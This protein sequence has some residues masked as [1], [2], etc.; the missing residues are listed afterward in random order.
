MQ[1]AFLHGLVDLR[2]QRAVL[3]ADRLGVATVD[4]ALEATEMR[5]HGAGQQPILGA[6]AL[7]ALRGHEAELS[8][9]T[10]T[11]VAE[12]QTRGEGLALTVTE[13]LSGV[14]YNG[15]GRYDEALAEWDLQQNPDR[16]PA[17]ST[18]AGRQQAMSVVHTVATSP[19]HAV[20]PAVAALD[21]GS[22]II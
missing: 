8:D 2:D 18:A 20:A 5:L 16:A 4:R 13:F 7:A 3:G 14:L 22:P 9:L 12:A 6:L 1:G 21:D 10:K 17:V 11:T 15:L 19:D